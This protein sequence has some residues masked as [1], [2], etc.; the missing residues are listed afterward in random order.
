LSRNCRADHSASA[1]DRRHNHHLGKY[2]TVDGRRG[3]RYAAQL[4]V[5]AQQLRSQLLELLQSYAQV[6]KNTLGDLFGSGEG[7]LP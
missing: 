4:S 5:A 3:W 2:V 1:P 7:A 6:L